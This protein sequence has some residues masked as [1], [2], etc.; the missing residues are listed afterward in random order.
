MPCPNRPN[1]VTLT[2]MGSALE[3]EGW[4]RAYCDREGASCARRMLR[5][6]GS[7]VPDDLLPDGGIL[8]T[9]GEL[10]ELTA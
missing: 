3:L 9:I 8:I 4:V 10:E 2:E 5:D 7:P 1:C 6:A